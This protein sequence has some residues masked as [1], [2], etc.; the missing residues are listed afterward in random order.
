M[1]H[2][3]LSS[4]GRR[5]WAEAQ[6]EFELERTLLSI[7]NFFAATT[8]N[9]RSIRFRAESFLSTLERPESTTF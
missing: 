7:N 8:P 4:G 9:S 5:R 1:S 2:S 3:S 6:T